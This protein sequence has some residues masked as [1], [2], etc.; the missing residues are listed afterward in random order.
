MED[1]MTSTHDDTSAV[2]LVPGVGER[3]LGSCAAG[4]ESTRGSEFDRDVCDT[5]TASRPAVVHPQVAVL[6][7]RGVRPAAETSAHVP[8][9]P[10]IHGAAAQFQEA[11]GTYLHLIA[12][13]GA[14]RQHRRY[15]LA[16]AEVLRLFATDK[17]LAVEIGPDRIH[18]ALQRGR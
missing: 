9:K 2:T 15:L 7:P 10:G 1:D 5:R 6:D 17:A 11:P 3:N 13:L 4:A 14:H 18:Y 12:G 16:T 8:N